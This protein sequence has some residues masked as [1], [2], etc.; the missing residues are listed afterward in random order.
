[1]KPMYCWLALACGLLSGCGGA[2]RRE[3]ISLG[4]VLTDG[5]QDFASANATEKQ[6]YT[7]TGNWA[8]AI[9]TKGAGSGA[10]LQQN[11][12]TAADL[13]KSA[14]L[15]SNQLGQLRKAVYDQKLTQ[16]F[17]QNVRSTL[18]TRLTTRQRSLQDLRAALT[19]ASSQFRELAQT[20]SYKGDS[21]PEAVDR[22][23]R[24]AQSH[25]VPTD[26]VGEALNSLKEEYGIKDV[27]L[28]PR[29]ATR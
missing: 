19:E 5:R 10:Q 15:V 7:A 9:V 16:D 23:S 20:R 29:T 14:D 18:I 6:V 17:T 25:S 3:A 12:S 28:A 24:M 22:L 8:D 2:A 21:Y 1:M 13:A 4:R 26:V 27:D 11:A